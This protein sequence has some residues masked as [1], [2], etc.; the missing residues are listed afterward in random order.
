MNDQN[1]TTVICI[2]GMRGSGKSSLTRKLANPH[3]RL[4]VFDR[5][6]EWTHIPSDSIADSYHS[7]ANIFRRVGTFDHYIIPVQFRR[8]ASEDDIATETEAILKLVY[9][10][11]FQLNRQHVSHPVCL[12]FEELQ[13][14]CNPQGIPPMLSEVLF[15]GRHAQLSII[16]NTQRPASIHKGF[17]SQADRILVGQLFEKR[18]I[19]YIAQSSFGADAFKAQTLEKYH[20]LEKAYGQMTREVIP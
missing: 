11:G 17:I 18:D 14:Y 12:V 9:D 10:F 7:F 4:V 5:L 19:E 15:T 20:F 3:A 13:F 1:Q 6:R 16:G 8:G 2:F